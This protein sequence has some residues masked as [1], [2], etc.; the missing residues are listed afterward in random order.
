VTGVAA[1]S[2]RNLEKKDVTCQHWY[3]CGMQ[4]LQMTGS[5][6]CGLAR[7][8]RS[9]GCNHDANQS[10]HKSKQQHG[11]L[12]TTWHS[13]ASGDFALVKDSSTASSDSSHTNER[14]IN[15]KVA[16]NQQQWMC[17]KFGHAAAQHSKVA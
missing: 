12:I 8:W 10:G 1:D 6:I 11:G 17:I 5:K 3:H 15:Q 16:M 4:L 2:R 9:T 7:K 13:A 14:K